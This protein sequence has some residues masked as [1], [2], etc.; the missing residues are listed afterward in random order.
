MQQPFIMMTRRP[1]RHRGH[2]TSLLLLTLLGSCIISQNLIAAAP[3]TLTGSALDTIMTNPN[4]SLL[5]TAINT[6]MDPDLVL[7]LKMPKSSEQ[8]GSKQCP[9]LTILSLSSQFSFT[10]TYNRAPQP[11]MRSVYVLR[12]KQ[13]GL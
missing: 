11:C 1:P 4:W 9:E 7:Y 8:Q 6:V 13:C 3:Y 5:A 12:S 10:H 2:C